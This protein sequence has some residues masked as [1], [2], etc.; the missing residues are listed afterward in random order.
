MSDS[1]EKR[2]LSLIKAHGGELVRQRKH[3]I[4]RF[5]SGKNFVV[6]NTPSDRRAWHHALATLRRLLGIQRRV[7]KVTLAP[8]RRDPSPKEHQSYPLPR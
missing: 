4:Y 8:K 5:P 1:E 3:H 7:Q 6:P 2:V